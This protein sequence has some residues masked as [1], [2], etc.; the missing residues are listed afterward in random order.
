M[1]FFENFLSSDKNLRKA[2]ENEFEKIK[3]IPF[4]KSFPIFKEGIQ[5]EKAEI[6][7]LANLLMKKV[8]FENKN[9]NKEE[10]FE[11]KNFIQN[12]INFNLN[13]KNFCWK[14][15]QRLGENL[16]EIYFKI[17]IN[18]CFNEV[19][20]YVNNNNENSKK[21]GIY[22][23][24]I[25]SEL[26]A[27]NDDLVKNNLNDFINLFKH[28]L[29]DNNNFNIKSILNFFINISNE[30][31]LFNFS[32]LLEIIYKNILNKNN[33]NL[34]EIIE[35]LNSLAE[36]HP[37][38]FC[39]NN[40]NNNNKN[41]D[42]FIENLMNFIIIISD[43][44]FENKIRICSLEII[45]SLSE[46]IPKKIRDSNVF[47]S[48]FLNKLFE[49]IREIDT[50]E[51]NLIEW[52]KKY[53]NEDKNN[54]NLEES[55]K[56]FV[57]ENIVNG[58]ERLSIN[59]SGKYFFGVIKEKLTILLKSNDWIDLHSSFSILNAICE[60]CEKIFSENFQEI[61]NFISNNLLFKNI[62]VQFVC[63]KSL[64][65]LLRFTDFYV[66][67][68]FYVNILT[69]IVKI[70]EN[71]SV[72]I[73]NA[74]CLCLE[75]IL[76]KIC[77]NKE[78][79]Y[80]D[81]ENYFEELLILFSSLFDLGIKINYFDMIENSLD[82][83]S[84]IANILEG[85]FEKYF[86]RIFPNLKKF[87]EFN[88]NSENE[89]K[90]K[91]KCI[92]TISYLFSAQIS[93]KN[94]SKKYLNELKEIC[95]IYINLLKNLPEEDPQI[96][97][98]L[99]SF[100]YISLSMGKEF[101]FYLNVLF[102]FFEEKINADINLT[103]TDNNIQSLIHDDNENLDNN[104]GSVVLNLGSVSKKFSL[105]TFALQ[106]KIIAFKTL[107]EISLNLN[108]NFFGFVEK[109][110]GFCVRL[111]NYPYSRIIRKI[112]MKGIF[113]CVNSCEGENERK[114]IL[115]FVEKNL[116]EILNYFVN[117]NHFREIKSSLKIFADFCELFEEGDSI[118]E[119]FVENLYV[120]MGMIV[121]SVK[122]KINS[123]LKINENE[124][125][126][127]DLNDFEEQKNDV[128][129]LLEINRRI[130]D[131][132]GI[133]YKLKNVTILFEKNLLEFFIGELND[134]NIVNTDLFVQEIISSVCVLNDY[135]EFS[136]IEVY[137]NFE[138]KYF[139]LVKN[140]DCNNFDI[141]QNIIVGVG[142]ICKRS[143]KSFFKKNFE[144][145]FVKI[146]ENILNQGKNDVNGILYEN[147]VFSFGFYVFNQLEINENNFL[148]AQKFLKFLPL[149][150]DLEQSEK[151]CGIFFKEIINK[152]PI[153]F[154]DVNLPFVKET[155]LKIIDYNKY[156]NFIKEEIQNLIFCCV[157]LGININNNN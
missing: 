123:I 102:P 68:K 22:L 153:I 16:A 85:K 88:A 117:N 95:E 146:F 63:L 131:L 49:Y 130:M 37:K 143:E 132:N 73:K 134:K 82:C 135:L 12:V 30:N 103:I 4:E 60:G 149:S 136:E 100:P 44:P 116:I 72:R 141:M 75:E 15:F 2:A 65:N 45:F 58:F 69:G 77:E 156:K 125:E 142:I 46:K 21:F 41:C 28:I 74:A 38:F 122:I 26:N 8:Y 61:L 104:V 110:L 144:F 154:N 84:L 35:S 113:S 20:F 52:E 92:E 79:F 66:Q 43:K 3:Q 24:E 83:I 115:S 13:N 119:F 6:N 51:N 18:E 150:E 152:N 54:N 109:F 11:I 7:Q 9:L 76:R 107:F 106:S 151:L 48:K 140:F 138:T 10:I 17:G 80:V 47:K 36:L 105:H 70:I 23:I 62:R 133:I 78:K 64:K 89:K 42:D 57:Y 118:S 114:K 139:D 32:I 87:L 34:F 96:I 137:R 108:K 121:K 97:S 111:L 33:E 129:K 99:N 25:L 145:S 120:L 31:L 5:S 94:D 155:I 40:N 101:V 14:S 112:A 39:N 126:F 67:S 98:I 19:L 147:C 86:E 59:L 56:E 55:E 29:N 71:N 124:K 53:K 50:S 127:F 27:I 128:K 90:L 81:V 1:S 93:E 148:I 91:S 157:E